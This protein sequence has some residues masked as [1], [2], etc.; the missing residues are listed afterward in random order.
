MVVKLKP[1]KLVLRSLYKSVL[2]MLP[3][4]YNLCT[5]TTLIFMVISTSPIFIPIPCSDS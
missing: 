1:V 5:Q 2:R 3:T 4:A